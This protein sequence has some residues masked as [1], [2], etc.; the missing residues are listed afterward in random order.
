MMGV[1]RDDYGF[2]NMMRVLWHDEA[3]FTFSFSYDMNVA[4][5]GVA[6]L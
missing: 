2:C 6:S 4:S 1:L 5:A 3:A